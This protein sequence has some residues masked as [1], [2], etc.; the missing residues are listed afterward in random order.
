[1][2]E[3]VVLADI[4]PTQEIRDEDM[5][6]RH[7]ENRCSN[8]AMGIAQNWRK[9]EARKEKEKK[10]EESAALTQAAMAK[11]VVIHAI[12]TGWNVGWVANTVGGRLGQVIGVSWLLGEKRREGKTAFLVVVY[13]NEEILVGNGARIRVGGG[14]HLMIP[15]NF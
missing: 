14:Q 1:M 6:M 9:A 13:L 2:S 12:P 10:K 3:V 15:Y 7:E 8:K 5:E 11:A 4:I